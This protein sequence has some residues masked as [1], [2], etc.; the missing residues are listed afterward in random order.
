MLNIVKKTLLAGAGLTLLTS[1]QAQEVLDELIAKGGEGEARQALRNSGKNRRGRPGPDE[2]KNRLVNDAYAFW[3]YGVLSTDRERVETVASRTL[4]QWACPSGRRSTT[5][6]RRIEAWRKPPVSP[7][8]ETPPQTALRFRPLRQSSLTDFVGHPQDAGHLLMDGPVG[9][10]DMRDTQGKGTVEEIRSPPPPPSRAEHP[11]TMSQGR[12]SAP[13]N[14]RNVPPRGMPD[15]GPPPRPANG[16]GSLCQGDEIVHVII[17]AFPN[18][19]RGTPLP[20][21]P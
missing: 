9:S 8:R 4:R 11:Q 20:G 19:Q 7:Q 15:P 21:A 12:A 13:K 1:G 17:T 16:L 14:R 10:Q 5:F 2:K 6:A 18:I 3:L